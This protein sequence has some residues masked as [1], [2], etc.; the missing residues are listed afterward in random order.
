MAQENVIDEVRAL[1]TAALGGNVLGLPDERVHARPPAQLVTPCVFVD[2]PTVTPHPLGMSISLPVFVAFDGHEQ[3][4][5]Q[6]MDWVVARAWDVLSDVDPCRV[7]SAAP[8]QVDVGGVVTRCVRFDVV[9]VLAVKTLCPA[10]MTLA[11]PA[12]AL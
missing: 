9:A 2:M 8:G 5:T 4:Q 1:I 10:S 6:S 7:D 3:H 12:P 11:Q